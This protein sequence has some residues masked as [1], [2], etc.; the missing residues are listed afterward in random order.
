[1]KSSHR[2]EE[3][4]ENSFFYLVEN[5]EE[6]ADIRKECAA[7]PAKERRMEAEWNYDASY[8]DEIFCNALARMGQEWRDEEPWPSG[9]VAL[10]MD[11]LF[12]PAILTVGSIEYHLG[13][14]PEA[15]KLF[16]QLTTL[17]KDEPDLSV[18]I[19]KAGDFLLD[20]NDLDNALLLYSEAEKA[21]PDEPLYPNAAGY[22]LG[23]MGRLSES[24]EKSKRSVE[25]DPENH[26]WLND[27]G[28]TF[29]LQG[30]LD[31][32]EIY[33]EKSAALAPEDYLFA[34]NNLEALR[35]EREKLNRK[36]EPKKRRKPKKTPGQ[37]DDAPNG[38]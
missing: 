3:L 24:L 8:A 1:M 16:L 36:S 22:C 29:M 26:M 5:N 14:V 33:L 31:E 7:L 2:L 25:M 35:E 17:P 27:L 13:R 9:I 4:K 11:P 21:F 32:A 19:D 10:A 28:Y 12:A 20:E 6:L 18:I 30:N 34:K 15:M 23:K 37:Q 38:A